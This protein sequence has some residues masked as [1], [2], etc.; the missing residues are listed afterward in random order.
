MPATSLASMKPVLS[1][2]FASPRLKMQRVLN[3]LIISI[4]SSIAVVVCLVVVVLVAILVGKKVCGRKRLSQ[5]G[6]IYSANDGEK[7]MTMAIGDDHPNS[8]RNSPHEY[9][10]IYNPGEHLNDEDRSSVDY[11]TPCYRPGQ[12]AD[13]ESPFTSAPEE[14]RGGNA[15]NEYTLVVSDDTA[16]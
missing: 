13:A 1:T 16:S 10:D 2:G 4:S 15:A 11:L 14:P 3:K 8:G 9:A 12:T 5:H 7:Q 6:F